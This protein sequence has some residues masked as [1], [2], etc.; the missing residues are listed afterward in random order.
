MIKHILILFFCCFFIAD[1]NAQ[2]YGNEWI[3]Y[4]QKYYKIKIFKNGVYRIDSATLASAGIAIGSM[5]VRNLQLFN[6][7][8]EVP[9]HIESS[10]LTLNKNEFIEFYAAKN[11]GALDSLLYVNTPH[12]PNPY[13]SLVNDTAMYYLTWNQSVN[14]S[15]ME[16]ETDTAFS[17][18]PVAPYYMHTD[19]N[20]YHHNY[21]N[22]ETD[23]YGG[24][25]SRY[26][27]S[28]TYGGDV[29]NLG[30]QN[31]LFAST[32]N[33]YLNGPAA[34]FT[35]MV[36]GASKNENL[37]NNGQADHHLTI[38]CN[39]NVL[40]D[41][42]FMGYEANYFKRSI[43][44]SI[45]TEGFTYFNYKSIPDSG[46]TSNRTFATY[47]R[48]D[49]PRTFNFADFK[50]RVWMQIPDAAGLKTKLSISNFNST[51]PV[52]LYDLTN[53]K[54]I[55]SVKSATT[56]QALLPNT[57]SERNCFLTSDDSILKISQLIPVS[58]TAQF[59]DF[60]KQSTDS[61]FVIITHKMLMNS[62]LEY[63]NYRSTNK[64]G[65][66]H[67]VVIADIDE[68]Y[69]QFGYG[70][71]KTPIAIRNFCKF[72][73]HFY[74]TPPENLFIIG[75]AYHL[76][77]IRGIPSRFAKCLVPTFGN[78]PSDNLLTSGLNPADQLVP[79]IPTGRLAAQSTRDVDAYL[80]KIMLFENKATNP[81]AEWMKQVLHFGGGISSFEQAQ[82]KGYLDYYKSVVE[83]TLFGGKVKGFFKTS[84]T[85]IQVNTSDTLK[86]LI[87]NGI[88]LMTFF[89][90]AYGS[91]FDQS[92]DDISVY[93]PIP[94]HYPLLLANSCYS[95]DIHA[96]M[97]AN[98]QSLS[99]SE[100]FVLTPERGTI[101]YL[102]GVSL[103]VPYALNTFSS[104]FYQEISIHN[105][106]KSI[107]SSIKNTIKDFQQEGLTD[108]LLR[109][110]SY[111][112]TFHG[113][114]SVKLPAEANPDYK[115]TNNSIY[116]DQKSSVD[117][118]TVYVEIT[119]IGRA[120]KDSI[121]TELTRTFP[122]GETQVYSLRHRA[123]K[124]KDTIS[125]KLWNDYAKGVGV[126][127]FN[128]IT[129]SYNTVKEDNEINNST[130]PGAT[131]VING[132]S[133]APVYPYNFSIV[134]QDTIT[135]KASTGDPLAV[136]RN[137]TFQIDTTDTFN[138]PLL[139]TKINSSGGV[140]SWHLP[141]KLA[142]LKVYYWRVSE[143]SVSPINGFNWREFSFQYIPEKRGWEQAHIFQFKDDAFQY[144]KFNR[145]KRKFDFF[146][147]T[148]SLSCT[149][150]LIPYI[151]YTNIEWKLND[152][153]KTYWSCV[154]NSSGMN[155]VVLDPITGENWQ[156][157]VVSPTCSNCY[158]GIY[159]NTQCR[160]YEYNAFEFLDVDASARNNITNFI[161]NVVPSGYYVLAYSMSRIQ[162]P[163]ENSVY[164]SF[165]LF[166]ASQFRNVPK[167]VPYIAF[168]KKGDAPGT[169]KEIIG[170]S[171]QSII[172]LDT[173]ITTNWNVGAISSPV[174]GPA[175]SWD[176]LSWA[177]HTTDIGISHD[178]I[179][180]RVL[181]IQPDGKEVGVVDFDYTKTDIGNLGNYIDAKKYPNIRLVAYLKDDSLHTPPQLD[182]WQVIYT[183]V[184]ELAINA[185][186]GYTF[187]DSVDNGA[188]VIMHLPIQNISEYTFKDSILVNYWVEDAARVIHPLPSK[189]KKNLF[190]PGELMIDTVV[191]NS[192]PFKGSCALW[193]E[194]NP[195]N[196]P[197][198]QLE[199]YHFNNV[200]R[201]GVYI[202][203]DR[204]N[205]LL[206][207]TF[208]GM[209]I[210][211]NELVSSK[212]SIQIQL[213]DENKY[214][215]LNDT[216]D[217]K[218]SLKEPGAAL[219]PIY[220]GST[221]TFVPAVLPNNSCRIIF[222]PE[223]IKDGTY[224]LVVRAYDK[225][226]NLSGEFDY[227]INFEVQNESSITHV[228][229][230]PN[231]FSTST[232]FVFTLTG[233]EVPTNF[234]IQIMTI[235]G[236]VVKEIFED[237]LGPLRIGKNITQYAWDGRDQF[238]D[239]LANG[240]YLY[241]VLTKLNGENIK[242]KE[243]SADG[244]FKNGWGKMYLIR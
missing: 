36:I 13:F 127:K 62:V 147:D 221:M 32:T 173:T 230:Y 116:F 37:L 57:G 156:T 45:L 59:T 75:K 69:D 211:N 166:G 201:N 150:G 128:A 71:V 193:A 1:L 197:K 11:D 101:G 172:E 31:T 4:A 89:G 7:G 138:S 142:P 9:L 176:S 60:L 29:M 122:G 24:T 96:I 168:G 159:G 141:F 188:E 111:D 235:S 238:G 40:V 237:E 131:V 14:N 99:S 68:L 161:T 189:L 6:K 73:I 224:Q 135:L 17:S 125:F 177:Q 103:G 202:K 2:S 88:A 215:A 84:T 25:D 199:Q 194:V 109:Q 72:L 120:I 83:D 181:G 66:Q 118:I 133:I 165:D 220:F 91:G 223:L 213:K 179:F 108:P 200:V 244:F 52:W 81:P 164:N 33:R 76:N 216:N 203:P 222:K 144:V 170:A 64:Y 218:V 78:P 195:I 145:A 174:I 180:V 48:V 148:K 160:E 129:D 107:G 53:S 42:T 240:V 191:L 5:D 10:D 87:N 67:H 77:D 242:R 132:G 155:I 130:N 93:N 102:G 137:Y 217:F 35:T 208:D 169:A 16:V 41:T 95:G 190:A 97:G 46:F 205:P 44:V 229:N 3:N 20:E 23:D 233:S 209:H 65:G 162:V 140:L 27:K 74:V 212:P 136:S 192:S 94:G 187:T 117:S 114:P 226:K 196:Q 86:Q 143:D 198:S 50:G 236:K 61:A 12:I 104:N 34:T 134:P 227:T 43:P 171:E 207:V 126:N 18:Y 85:P 182:K 151:P 183:P 124:F 184:P 241:R 119:N 82:L 152:Y 8:K 80:N 38:Q 167:N 112:M 30:G 15:R 105:Y 47:V 63:K 70:I 204:T 149:N 185:L 100:V 49:Y 19:V 106:G 232:R 163:Y 219:K 225:S 39:N 175:S 146:N 243:T 110:M 56:Y 154:G 206:D 115:V 22:G 26:V 92:I 123:P 157:T 51:G 228:L 234:K 178:S 239:Q 214:L 121:F 158:N 98:G 55:V 21:Y 28:E 153:I 210:M 54:R 58:S 113:D 90:H 231:P 186:K 139:T 79:A